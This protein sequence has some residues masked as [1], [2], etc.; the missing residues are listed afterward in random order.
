[1]ADQRSKLPNPIGNKPNR[2]L[3][4]RTG[5]KCKGN[6]YPRNIKKSITN[7]KASPE[8]PGRLK[9]EWL[10]IMLDSRT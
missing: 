7:I 2:N 5:I 10:G 9:S 6:H 3:A 4:D 8:E 1:M